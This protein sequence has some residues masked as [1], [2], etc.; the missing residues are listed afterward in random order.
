MRVGIEKGHYQICNL[1][2]TDLVR[3]QAAGAVPGNNVLVDTMYWLISG[4]SELTT[5]L[6]W[7][8]TR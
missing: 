4:V 5:L 7:D 6:R 3:T 8:I 2:V 1:L